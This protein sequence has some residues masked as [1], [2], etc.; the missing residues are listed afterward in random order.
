VNPKLQT[1]SEATALLEVAHRY[2]ITSLVDI[3]VCMLSGWLTE[4]NV[5][6]YLM[7]AEHVGLDKFRRRCL[8]FITSSHSRVAQVQTTVAFSRLAERRPALAIDIL[9]KVIP[10]SKRLRTADGQAVQEFGNI[11]RD[12]TEWNDDYQWGPDSESGHDMDSLLAVEEQMLLELAND[13]CDLAMEAEAYS[14]LC[15]TECQFHAP[16]AMRCTDTHQKRHNTDNNFW[17]NERRQQ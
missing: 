1:E 6:D 8:E 9:A 15:W 3:C 10:P 2:E 12:T 16:G 4:E 5:A 7:L 17:Q 14:L 11:M 13:D